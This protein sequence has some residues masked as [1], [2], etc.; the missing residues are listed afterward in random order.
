[1][2]LEV[3]LEAPDVVIAREPEEVVDGLLWGRV[4]WISGDAPSKQRE[5]ND[6]TD[7][8]TSGWSH[9]FVIDKKGKLVTLLCPYTLNAYQISRTCMEYRSLERARDPWTPERKKR[10]VRLI[11]EH[12]AE[13]ERLGWQ[14]GFD[15]A[16]MVLH[17]LGAEVP[18]RQAKPGEELKAS[19]GKD[20]DILGLLK[21]VKRNG[22]RGQ[23]LAFFL[24]KP[25]SVREAMAEFGV[26]R[27]NVLSQLYLLTK[28]HGIGYS[29]TGD[30]VTIALPPGCDDPF[31]EA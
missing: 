7:P 29:L 26:T 3:E 25:R 4:Y 5:R 12:W 16:A 27:S 11:H 15:A 22:R 30:A 17:A 19:G 23:V 2:T 24:E 20:A 14:R 10:L 21:P 9:V 18:Q 28:D 6:V 1:M 31:V 8:P 13:A